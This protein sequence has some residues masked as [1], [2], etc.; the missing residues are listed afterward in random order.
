MKIHIKLLLIAAIFLIIPS[1]LKSQ[2]CFNRYDLLFENG[3][4]TLN[5]ED[6]HKRELQFLEDLNGCNAIDFSVQ[7]LDGEEV[8]LSS[9]KGKI[10]VLNFWFTTCLPCLKEIPEL[11]KLTELYDRD[12]VVFIA[13]ARDEPEKLD[14]FFK[15]FGEF[16]YI[17]LPESHEIASQYNVVGWPQSMVIDKSG[18]IYKSW[19]GLH[20]SAVQQAIEIQ[21]AIDKCLI[22]T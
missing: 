9:F 22:Q 15:R 12:E 3:G 5:Y 14:A 7:S 2:D 16:K 8:I 6:F 10:V 11:N 13:L 17:I 20:H 1:V 18:R 21:K 4:D 19:A